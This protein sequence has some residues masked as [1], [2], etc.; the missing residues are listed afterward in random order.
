MR[1]FLLFTTIFLGCCSYQNNVWNEEGISPNSIPA[2]CSESP[3]LGEWFAVIPIINKESY[4]DFF[5]DCTATETYCEM[6]YEWKPDSQPTTTINVSKANNNLG[7]PDLG[8][9]EIEREYTGDKL[10]IHG[11][12]TIEYERLWF[13]INSGL[14][15]Q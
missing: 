6:E 1:G 2:D 15:E 14:K 3:I 8:E 12:V 5:P 7:C 11:I 4:L 10:I 13:G 9:N